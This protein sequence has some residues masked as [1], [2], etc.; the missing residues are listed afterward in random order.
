[1]HTL[2]D[3]E[4]LVTV[5]VDT[6][7]DQHVAVAVDSSDAISGR[8]RSQRPAQATPSSSRGRPSSARSIASELKAPAASALGLL[9]GCAGTAWCPRDRPARRKA[10]R[11]GKSDLIDAEAAA[12]AVLSGTATIVP[13]RAGGNVE[14]IRRGISTHTASTLLVAAGD[15]P[16]R[17]RSEGSFAHPTGAAPLDASSGKQQRHRLTGHPLTAGTRCRSR[18]RTARSLPHRLALRGPG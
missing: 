10:R 12:R 17:L 3:P 13:K 7:G 4:A 5:G 18:S 2:P 11:R 8:P 16:H 9:D 14:M 1:M 15:N 6:H